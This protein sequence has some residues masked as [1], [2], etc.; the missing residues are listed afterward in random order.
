MVADVG[1]DGAGE[2]D[3]RG[4]PRHGHDLAPWGEDDP[5][6][7]EI[8]L[9][10]SKT[11][12]VAALHLEERLQPFVGLDLRSAPPARCPCRANGGDALLGDVVHLDGADLHFHRRAV[13]ADQGSVQGWQPLALGMAM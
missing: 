2:I 13:G 7:E 12:R 10:F 6:G 1:M 4:A 9:T 8:D 3:H 11:R 5:V